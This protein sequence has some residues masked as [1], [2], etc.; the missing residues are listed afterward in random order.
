MEAARRVREDLE[1]QG[2]EHGARAAARDVHRA[3][4]G[5][6]LRGVDLAGVGVD[7]A[8]ARG[9]H[10]LDA[11]VPDVQAHLHEHVV[12]PVGYSAGAGDEGRHEEGLREEV[13]LHAELAGQGEANQEPHGVPR[14]LPQGADEQLRRGRSVGQHLGQD[15]GEGVHAAIVGEVQDEA[16][17][18]DDQRRAEQPVAEDDLPL[19]GDDRRHGPA[20]AAVGA[21]LPGLPEVHAD[22]GRAVLPPHRLQYLGGLLSAPAQGQVGGRLVEEE[23]GGDGQDP[24]GDGAPPE[25]SSPVQVQ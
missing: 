14:D 12:G 24:A 3:A 9:A 25:Q 15:L 22:V 21:A 13:H 7:D 2:R 8:E 11:V 23:Q 19:P 18:H 4:R 17:V 6:G 1:D 20:L 10:G 5:A 16:A